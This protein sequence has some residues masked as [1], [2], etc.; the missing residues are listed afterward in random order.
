MTAASAPP[1]KALPYPSLA[2]RPLTLVLLLLPLLRLLVVSSLWTVLEADAFGAV[3]RVPA[4]PGGGACWRKSGGGNPHGRAVVALR[5]DEAVK[6]YAG[7]E[8]SEGPE[9]PPYFVRKALQAG[10]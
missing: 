10:G 9:S 6:F 5:V 2:A 1:S 8:G 4:S 3:R 7:G